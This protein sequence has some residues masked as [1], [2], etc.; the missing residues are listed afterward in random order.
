MSTITITFGD[1]A[2]N[3]RGMQ[4]I[5]KIQERGYDKEELLLAK[6]V[7]E[8]R[9]YVCELVNLNDH[10]EEAADEAFVLVIKRGV[11]AL[12][13]SSDYSS[14]D[15]FEELVNLEWDSKILNYGKVM[16]KR[17]RYNLCFGNESQEPLYEQGKGRIIPWN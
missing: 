10:L 8:K 3:H 2:E 1:Q 7:F 6:S 5:G 12:L 16:N 17:A 11:E 14:K 15:L 4:K 13:A 9:G